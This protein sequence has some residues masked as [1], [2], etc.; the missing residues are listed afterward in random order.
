M[1]TVPFLPRDRKSLYVRVFIPRT[2][3]HHFKNRAEL[4]RTLQTL[5]A[6]DAS[7]GSY[8]ASAA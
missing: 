4:W 3:Q 6:S 2:L 1:A 7:W 5:D 8:P